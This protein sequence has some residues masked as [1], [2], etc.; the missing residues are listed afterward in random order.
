M[1][2]TVSQHFSGNGFLPVRCEAIGLFPDTHMRRECRE[3]FPRHR[4]THVPWY[5]PGSLT[6][7]FIW[8]RWR[9]KHFW[10]SRFIHNPQFYVSCKR[11]VAWTDV[12]LLLLLLLIRPPWT[13]VVEI[14]NYIHWFSY[15]EPRLK[16]SANSNYVV[17]SLKTEW[18]I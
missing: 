4:V 1:A 9:E 13:Q 5:M 3:L 17:L 2:L 18:N 10:H 11:P 16:M 15:E 6:S 7:G 14:Q 8:N 12:E